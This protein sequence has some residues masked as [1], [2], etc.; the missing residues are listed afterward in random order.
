MGISR[1]SMARSRECDG[2]NEV[3]VRSNEALRI[4]TYTTYG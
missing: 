4:S 1:S 2:K 3:Q